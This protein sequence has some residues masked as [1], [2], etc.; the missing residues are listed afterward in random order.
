MLGALHRSAR[1]EVLNSSAILFR[2]TLAAPP[3]GAVGTAT[4][5]VTSAVSASTLGSGSLDVF[6]TPAMVALME[7]ASCAA[8]APT[9]DAGETTVGTKV[10]VVHLKCTPLGMNV[11][12]EATVTATKSN[13]FTLDVVAFDDKEKIGQGTHQRAI[14]PA[15]AFF[16]GCAKKSA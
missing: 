4:K 2:R 11:R 8:V 16:E 7:E 3:V 1:S 12:A 5:K 14:V 6:G 15:A 10:D 13:F 9:L